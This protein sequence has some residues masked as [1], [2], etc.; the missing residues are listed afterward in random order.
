MYMKY[1]AKLVMKD[2]QPAIFASSASQTITAVPKSLCQ[3][4]HEGKIHKTEATF[5]HERLIICGSSW[6]CIIHLV[7]G[8]IGPKQDSMTTFKVKLCGL[9]P[10]NVTLLQPCLLSLK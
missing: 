3:I 7:G 6:N 5:P 1:F 10:I 4:S 8:G 9:T 2:I